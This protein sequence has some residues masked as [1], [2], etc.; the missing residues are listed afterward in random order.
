MSQWWIRVAAA[1]LACL[2]VAWGQTYTVQAGDTLWRISRK[3]G[4]PLERLQTI[5]GLSG[6]KIK[7]GMTLQVTL[8]TNQPVLRQAIYQQ[9][10]AAWYGPGFHGQKT[11]SGEWFDT[12]GLTAAHRVLPFGSRVRVTNTRNGRTVV[13]RINDRGP[14]TRGFIIDLSYG[15]ARKLGIVGRGSA[16]VTLEVLR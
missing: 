14:Y 9:G 12:Y 2:S 4:I 13:V 8:Q 16:P 10:R 11:A 15:A 7:P 3:F 6:T 1:V 5:N